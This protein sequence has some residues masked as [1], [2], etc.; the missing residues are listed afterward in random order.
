MLNDEPIPPRAR[1][2]IEPRHPVGGVRD[3]SFNYA[4]PRAR[5]RTASVQLVQLH[6]GL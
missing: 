2:L 3:I 5:W 6:G 1:T 4:A